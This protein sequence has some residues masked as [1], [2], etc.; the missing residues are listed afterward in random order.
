MA[1]PGAPLL[2]ARG[3]SFSISHRFQTAQLP[4]AVSAVD[5]GQDNWFAAVETL[6]SSICRPPRFL[7]RPFLNP[8]RVWPGQLDDDEQ[9]W[10][11]QPPFS[12]RPRSFGARRLRI[13]C[14]DSLTYEDTRWSVVLSKCIIS[15]PLSPW[16]RLQQQISDLNPLE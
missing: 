12:R 5:N 6:R 16:S 1:L 3:L 10:S 15:L 9:W 11:A 7:S 14:P 13:L 4:S 2:R 8:N